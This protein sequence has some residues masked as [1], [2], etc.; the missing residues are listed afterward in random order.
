[1]EFPI[2]KSCVVFQ[3][4][5]IWGVLNVCQPDLM[6][7]K[8]NVVFTNSSHLVECGPADTSKKPVDDL[9]KWDDAESKTE[10]KEPSEGCNE[11]DRTHSDAS[12]KLWENVSNSWKIIF[13]HDS[14]LAKEDV[15]NSNVLL[16]SIVEVILEIGVGQ[17]F[18]CSRLYRWLGEKQIILVPSPHRV[19]Q[20]WDVGGNWAVGYFVSLFHL[21]WDLKIIGHRRW[22]LITLS[23]QSAGS[24]P[25]FSM[26]RGFR[27]RLRESHCLKRPKAMLK[28]LCWLTWGQWWWQCT[29]SPWAHSREGSRSRILL[30]CSFASRIRAPGLH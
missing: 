11:V 12:L 5:C 21:E 14:V 6:L 24:S 3:S 2:I 20:G 16:P 25:A 27:L 15:D 17:T 1:M 26:Q 29:A 28:E 18:C 9:Q 4:Q 8:I 30:S 23:V 7:H 22:S 19:G 10:A 13:T